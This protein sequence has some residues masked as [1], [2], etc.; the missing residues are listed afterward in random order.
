MRIHIYKAPPG[1]RSVRDLRFDESSR[2]I[3]ILEVNTEQL[4]LDL[5]AAMDPTNGGA[6]RGHRVRHVV[7]VHFGDPHSGLDH[8]E[9]GEPFLSEAN[10][11]DWLWIESLSDGS[12]LYQRDDREEPELPSD[13]MDDDFEDLGLRD[14]VQDE[15][16]GGAE[17]A[18]GDDR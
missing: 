3:D 10:A 7:V 8:V 17:D 18:T 6:A 16:E 13:E 4:A 15:N 9:A 12:V 14:D 2:K 11:P 5:E 1:T